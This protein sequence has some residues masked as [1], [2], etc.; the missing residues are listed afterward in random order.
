[1]PWLLPV[2]LLSIAGLLALV[3]ACPRLSGLISRIQFIGQVFVITVACIGL[4][5]LGWLVLW[6]IEQRW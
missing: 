5:W 2:E 4:V 3:L 1:M 6:W